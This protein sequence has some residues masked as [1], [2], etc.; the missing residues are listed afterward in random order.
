[1]Y[2]CLW[3]DP[4]PSLY[5]FAEY[6]ETG[7]SFALAGVALGCRGET[8]GFWYDDSLFAAVDGL[9][10][11]SPLSLDCDTCLGEA[12]VLD[13]AVA[14]DDGG[15]ANDDKLGCDDNGLGPIREICG[16]ADGTP[17]FTCPLLGGMFSCKLLFMP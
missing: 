9:G 5:P 10:T 1:M 8:G 3:P 15:P 6:C 2:E 13:S 14:D 4:C 17:A 7:L 16:D 11:A 12:A